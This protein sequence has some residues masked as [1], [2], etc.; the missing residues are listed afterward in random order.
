MGVLDSLAIG[1][2][3]LGAA[4][5]GIN[6]TSQNVANAATPGYSRRRVLQ[7]TSDPLQRGGLWLGTGVN[8]TGINRASDRFLGGRLVAAAGA[9][10]QASALESTLSVVQG[11]FDETS[12]TG[13]SEAYG[14][15][16]SS[17]S[18]LTSNPSDTGGRREVVESAR[19]LASTVSRTAQG[20]A[21][22][23]DAIDGS[24]ADRITGINSD[25]SQI[26]ALN[27]AI[28]KQGASTGPGDLLDRRD[29][30]IRGLGETA[31]ATVDLA[32]NGQATVFLG[33]IAVVSGKEARTLSVA[34][35]SL[36]VSQVFV[37]SDSGR[38]RVTDKLGG[39]LGGLL[40]AR[41]TMDGWL[42]QLDD[43]A[44]NLASTVNAQHALGFDATGNPGGDVFSIDPSAP[45]Q[46][47]DV[48]SSLA[49]DPN[50]LAVAGAATA[51]PGDGDNL[52]ALLALRSTTTFSG[53]TTGA[54][55]LSSLTS[56]VGSEVASASADS[57]SLSAQLSDLQT[58]RDAISKV[59][60]DE[61]AI[62]LIEFQTAYRAAS[63]VIAAGDQMLQTLLA[64]G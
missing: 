63:R 59:D 26:A 43:F 27:A 29:E 64:I 32:A 38:L 55:M 50:L 3:A 10:A 6:T 61:E 30:L 54:T 31:G 25:L 24:L 4:S 46:S 21:D 62:K 14:S 36:G 23:I 7:Q 44:T 15:F 40:S 17:M 37:S 18:K 41:T 9:D 35:D 56:S 8:V 22:G 5:A 13:L 51:D 12:G 57:T 20:L 33:G 2:R 52:T 1:R 48:D 42:G 16:Y 47:L 45:A 49:G 11:Y 19:T 39:E 58:Q 34:D 60:T 53:S 28:G